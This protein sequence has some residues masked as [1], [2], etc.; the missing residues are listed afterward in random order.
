[1]KTKKKMFAWLLVLTMVLGLCM[2]GNVLKVRAEESYDGYVYLT[3]EK[4]T[5]GQG[6]ILQPVKVG[7]HNGDNVGSLIFDYVGADKLQGSTGYI[8][9]VYD[10]GEPE[11]WTVETIPEQIVNALGGKD[12]IG[13]RV[14][15]NT[16]YLCGNDYK[17]E[18]QY[19]GW[20]F[21]VDD[22]NTGVGMDSYTLTE[23]NDGSV[24]RLQFSLYGCGAD[25]WG[26]DG[27]GCDNL[28]EN[29]PGKSNL[30]KLVADYAGDK[31]VEVY[32]D[33]L[34]VLSD[35]DATTEEVNSAE[36][37]LERIALSDTYAAKLGTAID[38]LHKNTN[39]A[40]GA[41]WAVLGLARNQVEDVKWYKDYYDSVVSTVKENENAPQLSSSKSTEN[42]RVIIGLSSIG[43][44]ATDI[45]G[46][47][48]TEPL[49][50]FSYVGKQGLNG[51]IYALIALD[52][53]NY[54]IPTVEDEENQTTREKLVNTILGK[55]IEN[56]GWAYFGSVTDPDMTG[57]VI[58]ALASYYEEENVKTAIDEA[59]VALS[60]IQKETGAFG[61]GTTES[62][63]SCAQVICALSALGIDADQDS[64]FVKN[65]NSVL[66]AM[67]SFYDESTG[68][69]KHLAGGTVDKMASTQATYALVAYD[70]FKNDKNS[71]YNM[72]DAACLY[73]C[74]ADKHSW[75]NGKVTKEPTDKE[76][77]EEIYTCTVC[78][79]TEKKT[80]PVKKPAATTQE[81]TTAS[82]T[83]KPAN[84]EDK[85]EAPTGE[86]TTTEELKKPTPGKTS[87]KKVTSPKKKQIK[88]TWN[89]KS[90]VT[91]YQIQVSTASSFKK[92]KTKTYT[93][94]S[95][96]TTSK[97]IKS[98]KSK[99]KYYVRIRTYKKVTKN[100]K[101]VTGYSAWSKKKTIKVK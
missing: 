36:D 43:A 66:D 42:S 60:G 44:D 35:W 15:Q 14:S 91:G 4:S 101:S 28:W 67:L 63:E 23:A 65:G 7:Y 86:A 41:E 79:E 22:A 81:K 2:P 90:G 57:M 27:Y 5:L 32:R 49:A 62:P 78:D 80:L 52:C 46:Y 84:T 31:T 75:D 98:L 97:T 38:Y 3:I 20:M 99:K 30:V 26:I 54:N 11:G 87:L 74:K 70:R 9:G 34:E 96:K 39:P 33:A 16:A 12:G 29:F 47:D 85:T 92:S 18:G 76:T 58:Q 69:F 100:G 19:P 61:F 37:G 94:K 93:V 72:S 71:L 53:G 73:K 17:V 1:M 45:A 95:N 50:D 77:G 21:T 59:L 8:S 89:K 51:Y 13:G 24:V 6:L 48:L 25:I 55:R 10:G 82:T 56:G 83:E 40:F 88:V 68:G 64:R